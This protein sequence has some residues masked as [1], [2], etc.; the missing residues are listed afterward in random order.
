MRCGGDGGVPVGVEQ[1]GWA[2]VLLRVPPVGRAGGGAAGT[3]DALVHAI[4]LGPVG[5]G[6]RDLL[7]L[8]R[9]LILA[10]E[11]WLDAPHRRGTISSYGLRR[12]GGRGSEDATAADFIL[13]WTSRSTSMQKR[14]S[15][16][17]RW[18][19]GSEYARCRRRCGVRHHRAVIGSS[20]TTMLAT[21][22]L[23]IR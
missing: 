10:L 23:L 15:S 1:R 2:E 14:M 11:P 13:A 18:V 22:L 19:D 9:G 4:E 8:L 5:L 20:A 6:L 17:G 16:P 7:A 3:E 12:R 21:Q